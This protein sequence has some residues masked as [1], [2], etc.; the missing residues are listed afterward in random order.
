MVSIALTPFLRALLQAGQMRCGPSSED[1]ACLLEAVVEVL[2]CTGIRVLSERWWVEFSSEA[3]QN[4]WSLWAFAVWAV[5][6]DGVSDGTQK[7]GREG[8]SDC[9][10][11]GLVDQK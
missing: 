3:G 8:L 4:G 7:D 10:I 2:K 1:D 9:K 5:V 6:E 11:H